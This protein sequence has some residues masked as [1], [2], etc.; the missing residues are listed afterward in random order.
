MF[1]DPAEEMQFDFKKTSTKRYEQ[2]YEHLELN[3]ETKIENWQ[4]IIKS[5]VNKRRLKN[6][7]MDELIMNFGDWLK[8]GQTIYMNGTFRE[9]VVKV[10]QKNEFEYT[11]FETQKDLILKVGESDSKIFF[12]I[13][14]LRTLFGDKFKKFLVYSLDTDVKF[15]SLYFSSLL[16]NADIV[17]KHGRGLSQ[18]F[19]HPK[20]VLEIMKT[21]FQLSTQNEVLCF[22][23]NIL[24]AY[25]Y[26]GCDSNPGTL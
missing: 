19:F 18:M 17:I 3:R 16:P 26:F 1:D 20:K 22:S 9:G 5:P 6:I 23:K 25:L 10:C 15:L 11:S 21:E 4:A 13:K 8:V 2:E 24:Q 7:F 12:A 14:H